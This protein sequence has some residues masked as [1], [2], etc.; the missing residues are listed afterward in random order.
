MRL[1][2]VCGGIVVLVM[3]ALA[4]QPP[5][6][7]ARRAPF[8]R[9]LWGDPDLQGAWNFAAGTPLER[10]DRFGGREFMTD[11]MTNC[12]WAS[13]PLSG[14]SNQKLSGDPS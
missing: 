9:T 10:P 1:L 2:L 3:T 4:T 5:G 8:P 11:Q 6:T 14:G 12:F 13:V 7:R